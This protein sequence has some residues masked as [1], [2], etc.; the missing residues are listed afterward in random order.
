MIAC[1]L[2]LLMKTFLTLGVCAFCFAPGLFSAKSPVAGVMG[3]YVEIRSCDVYAGACIANSEMNLSGREGMLVWSFRQGQWN[4]VSLRGLSV[5]AVVRTDETLGD[6]RYHPCRGKAVLIVDA[7]A[8]SVQEAALIAF[9]KKTAGSLVSEVAAVKSSPIEVRAGQCA[10]GACARVKAGNLV[11]ISTRCLGGKDHLCGNEED[12]YPPLT[13]VQTPLSAFTEL[14]SY[15]G[16]ALN[17]TWELTAKR[18]AYLATFAV[19]PDS[20]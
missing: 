13:S 12:F 11:E 20:L 1:D 10:S 17:M 5:I 6:R 19:R 14:A 9:V 8:D 15:K 4:G 3:D 2:R 16:P 7:Q 18:S